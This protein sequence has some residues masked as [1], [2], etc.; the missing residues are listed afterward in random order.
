[1]DKKIKTD[2]R[3]INELKE[4]RERYDELKSSYEKDIS[5]RNL[6]EKKCSN[7]QNFFQL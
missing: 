7:V 2:Q 1:M 4:L 5:A 3:L 6:A